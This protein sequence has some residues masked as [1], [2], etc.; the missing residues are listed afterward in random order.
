[1]AVKIVYKEVNDLAQPQATFTVGETHTDPT[2][3]TVKATGRQTVR[4]ALVGTRL[5]PRQPGVPQ[6]TETRSR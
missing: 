1:M 6:R 5:R 3:L 4:M 2:N